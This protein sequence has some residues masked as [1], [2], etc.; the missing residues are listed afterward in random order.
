MVSRRGSAT[1]GP[2]PLPQQ[3]SRLSLI[4]LPDQEN[5][6]QRASEELP[7]VPATPTSQVQNARLSVLQSL[8]GVHPLH[9]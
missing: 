3:M 6:S 9:S 4:Q 8:Y 5:P 2:S 1:A 7:V